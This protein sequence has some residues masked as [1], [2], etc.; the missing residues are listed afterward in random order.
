MNRCCGVSVSLR[1]PLKDCRP[2]GTVRKMTAGDSVLCLAGGAGKSRFPRTPTDVSAAQAS[3]VFRRP[4]SWRIRLLVTMGC[5]S[6][7]R[8][9]QR[10]RAL[11][12]STLHSLRGLRPAS[13]CVYAVPETS[14][15]AEGPCPVPSLV[16]APGDEFTTTRDLGPLGMRLNVR[17]KRSP[18][19]VR[20]ARAGEN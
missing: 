15:I 20:Q 6:G 12:L 14:E 11:R 3:I 18:T 2:R 10:M 9:R 13:S 4:R 7:S 19:V 1:L 17:A 5:A 8:Q 16:L